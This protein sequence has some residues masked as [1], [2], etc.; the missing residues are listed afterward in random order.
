LFII[1]LLQTKALKT[2]VPRANGFLRTG[3]LPSRL[4]CRL[5]NFAASTFWFTVKVHHERFADLTPRDASGC[6]TAGR[7]FHP[8]LKTVETYCEAQNEASL[9][10]IHQQTPRLSMPGL[11]RFVA[12]NAT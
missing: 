10:Q 12:V 8:A 5:Q 6:T 7:E 1:A 9:F 11:L 4:Y 3:L 2:F